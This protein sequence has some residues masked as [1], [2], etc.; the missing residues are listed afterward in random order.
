MKRNVDALL[1]ARGQTRRD[2]AFWCRR[3]DAWISKIMA[4]DRREFPMKYF[5]RIADFFGIA[6]YQL[7]QPGISHLT[8]RRV[9]KDRRT[10]QERRIGAR[11]P[12]ADVTPI[13]RLD[14]TSEDE[15]VLADIRSLSYED[16][17]RLK[18]WLAV[19]RAKR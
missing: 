3:G 1:K 2:L 5:D 16:V 11:H 4:E 13:R 12:K 6:T 17:R 8:E 19:T 10:G 18:D 9:G 15:A 7:L 14:L